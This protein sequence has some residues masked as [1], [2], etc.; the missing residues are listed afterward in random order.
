MAGAIWR[1]EAEAYELLT[2]LG[3]VDT[4]QYRRRAAL[5]SL[6]AWWADVPSTKPLLLVRAVEDPETGVRRAALEALAQHFREAVET[7]PLLLRIAK[8][9]DGELSGYAMMLHAQ[10]EGDR[11]G[12]ILLSGDLDAL[13][14]GIDPIAAIDEAR[15]TEAATLLSWTEER[16]RDAYERLAE[17]FALRVG[18]RQDGKPQRARRRLH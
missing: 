14:P 12:A 7:K 1:F 16:V 11:E 15:V 6:A 2:E 4:D 17:R 13:W 3:R 10:L 5:L 18:W 9:G 8:A